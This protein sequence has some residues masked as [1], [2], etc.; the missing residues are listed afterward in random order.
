MGRATALLFL[1][2]GASVVIGDLNEG[3]AKETLDL[4]Q[5][6]GHRDRIRSLR[7]DVAVEADVEAM[8]GLAESEFGRLDCVFNNAG[9]GGAIGPITETD[10]DDWDYT[11]AVLTRGV[12]LGIKHG[13]RAMIQAGH[14]GAIVNTASI[15]GLSGSAGPQAYSA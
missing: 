13:A 10:V 6:Q 1:R 2:E 11:F 15:A 8:I 12:F 7:V 14:G 5:E 9:L 4:A 3:T